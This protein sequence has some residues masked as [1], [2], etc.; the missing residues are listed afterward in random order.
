MIKKTLFQALAGVLVVTLLIV[1]EGRAATVKRNLSQI[2]DRSFESINDEL[3]ALLKSQSSVVEAADPP[4]INQGAVAQ[5]EP[6]YT[7]NWP[8]PG[9]PARSP[10]SNAEAADPP[11]INQE[12]AVQ[13]D[14]PRKKW[15][16]PGWPVG[17]HGEEVE[18]ADPSSQQSNE[19]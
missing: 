2:D 13:N 16:F 9:W 19:R 7:P 1:D 3:A 8:F 11:P 12:A 5:N 6:P 14:P 10:S 18:G 17:T 4:P 15:P